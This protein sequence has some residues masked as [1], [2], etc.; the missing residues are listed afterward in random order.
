MNLNDP[1][2]PWAR[3]TAAARTVKDDRDGVAPYGFATRVAAVA[4][5][6][7]RPINSL[8]ERFAWRAV[9]VAGLLA[10]ASLAMNYSALTKTLSVEEE[11]V[12]ED[13]VSVLLGA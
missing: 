11:M 10:L 7:E 1:Q 2:H 9:G 12:E 6:V 3:L 8:L 13:P 4:F 5:A